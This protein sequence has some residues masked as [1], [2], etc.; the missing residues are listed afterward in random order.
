MP[1]L[2]AIEAPPIRKEAT[3]AWR[4]GNS[5]VLVEI[6]IRAFDDGATPES[7]CK[8]YPAVSLSE[9]YDLIAYYLRHR[10]EIEDYMQKRDLAAEKLRAEWEAVQGDQFKGLKERLLARKASK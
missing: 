9:V 6:V 2:T 4:V 7:I 8:S 5:R 1:E 3:G 10:K